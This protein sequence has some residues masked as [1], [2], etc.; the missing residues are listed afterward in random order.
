[1]PRI[2]SETIEEHRDAVR[3]ALLDAT[4]E[5]VSELGLTGISMAAVAARVGIGRAT[6]YKYFPDIE[7]LLEAWHA[8]HISRHLAALAEVR[9]KHAAPAGQLTAVLDA[10]ARIVN[11]S[12]RHGGEAASAMLHRGE[13]VAHARRHLKVIVKDVLS[14]GIKAGVVRDDVPADELAGFALAALSAAAG[15]SRAGVSRLV[16]L[17]L[18]ALRPGR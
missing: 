14:R 17:T 1:M 16:K 18:E 13:H 9:G 12:A 7:A 5:L 10:Y 6:L 11:E 8:R 3:E 4:G 15:L 2:W